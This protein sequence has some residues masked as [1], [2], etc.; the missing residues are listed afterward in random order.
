MLVVIQMRDPMNG[1][2]FRPIRIT[3]MRSIAINVANNSLAIVKR[4]FIEMGI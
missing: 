4:K 2:P 1:T 3:L